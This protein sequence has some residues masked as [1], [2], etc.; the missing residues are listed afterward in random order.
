MKCIECGDPVYRDPFCKRCYSKMAMRRWR[1]GTTEL[2]PKPTV[3]QRFLAKCDRTGECWLWTGRTDRDYGTFALTPNQ[4]VRAHRWAYEHWVGPIPH[5]M[6]IDHLCRVRSCVNPLH[7]RTTTARENS[8]YRSAQITHCPQGHP[9]DETNTL[10]SGGRRHC[11]ECG[12]V[13]AKQSARKYYGIPDSVVENKAKTHCPAGHAYT[14]HGV[15]YKGKRQCR[16]CA[17]E[18]MRRFRAKQR[19]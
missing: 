4:G 14:E 11:R 12:R 18:A 8:Q 19:S 2:K 17:T 5:G 16:P 6:Q 13:R 1:N 9:Y 10:V 15:A 3:E 7:L